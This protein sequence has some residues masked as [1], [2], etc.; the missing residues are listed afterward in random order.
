MQNVSRKIGWLASS[1]GRKQL[2]G[3]TGLGLC[4]FLFTHMAGNM[5]ILVSAQ[6]YN[7]YSH[8]LISNP[9][10]YAA[11]AGLL[12][13]FVAHLLFALRLSWMNFQARDTRYAVLPNG[14]KRTKWSQRT[15]WAQGLLILVFAILHVITFKYGP[16]YT[17]N[18]GGVEMRDLHKLVIEVFSMPGYV[19][20]YVVALFV[21]FFHVCHGFGSAFQTLGINHPRYNPGIKALSWLYA[22]VVIGGFLSQPLYVLFFNQG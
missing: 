2:I 11:E 18:Y 15:L 6:K 3:L 14:A 13:M 22:I 12:A 16:Y 8:A 1:V 20:W 7:E 17:V 10:I 4:G 21:L 5:L 19:A 9:L